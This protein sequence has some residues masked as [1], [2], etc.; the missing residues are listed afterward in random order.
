[1]ARYHE[2]ISLAAIGRGNRRLL[3]PL[4]ARAAEAGEDH[5]EKLTAWRERRAKAAAI[6][7][8]E[9]R[10]QALDVV[11]DRPMHP[12]LVAAGCTVVSAV[13]LAGVPAVRHHAGVI[14]TGTLTLW[15]ITALILGQAGA[16]EETAEDGI[17]EAKEE[18]DGGTEQ[19]PAATAPTPDDARLAVAA[20]GASGGHVALTAVT[21]HLAAQ[22]PL[23]K[24][25]GK[26]V[27]ALLGEAGVRVR[28][29]VRVEGVSVEGIHRDDVP[30]LPSPSTPAPGAVVVAGQS[31]NNNANNIQQ[32]GSGEGF[33]TRPDPDNPARTIVVHTA[34]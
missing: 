28:G 12:M 1:M 27:R 22:H 9:Q 8:P 5:A 26:A 10:A 30:A 31:N 17:E 3:G 11:G 6:K 18:S 21:A 23:W 4:K 24:R 20:L 7:D 13:V 33:I 16:V 25:S 32:V 14:A 29:G 2:G 15:L 34:A 19:A